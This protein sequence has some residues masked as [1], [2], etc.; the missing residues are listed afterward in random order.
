MNA[1][2]PTVSAEQPRYLRPGTTPKF[3]KFS[4]QKIMCAITHVSE[5]DHVTI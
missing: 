2:K 3:T 4:E 1:L 5:P